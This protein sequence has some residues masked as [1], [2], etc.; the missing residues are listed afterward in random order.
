MTGSILLLCGPAATWAVIPLAFTPFGQGPL[1]PIGWKV[2]LVW[3]PLSAFVS[4]ALLYR[5]QYKRR[6]LMTGA[7]PRKRSKNGYRTRVSIAIGA[8]ALLLVSLPFVPA[9]AGVGGSSIKYAYQR[10]TPEVVGQFLATRRGPVKLFTWRDPQSPY[11]VDALR[12]HSAEVAGLI[13]RA[14]AVDRPATYGLF[15]LDHGTRIPLAVRSSSARQLSCASTAVEARPVPV[16]RDAPGDVR[17]ARLRVS[18]HRSA[19]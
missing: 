2:E 4:A 16:R 10:F 13:G 6:A 8:I 9:V 3:L 5:A 19:G 18:D 12:I 17:R 1:S 11:P 14:A 15:D 7:P